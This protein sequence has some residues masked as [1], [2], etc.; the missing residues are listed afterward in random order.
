M[1]INPAI[2]RDYDVRGLYPAD[3]NAEIAR[4]IGYAFAEYLKKSCR[5]KR[6]KISIARDLRASSTALRQGLVEGIIVAGADCYDLGIAT[7]PQAIYIFGT[8]RERDGGIMITASHNP[9][10][11]NGFKLFYGRGKEIGLSSGLR[12]IRSLTRVGAKKTQNNFGRLIPTEAEGKRYVKKLHR[13]V[14]RLDSLRALI[15]AAGGAAAY[16]LPDTLA[17]YRIFYKPIFFDPDPAFHRHEPNPLAPSVT[18]L[19]RRELK[20]AKYQVG[21][22]FDGDGDRAEF[23]DEKGNPIRTDILFGLL[24]VRELEKKRGARFVFELTH[25][26]FLAP[27]IEAYGG[28]LFVTKVGGV[29]VRAEMERVGAVLGGEISGHIYHQKL[30]NIDSAIYTMLRVFSLV[31]SASR[32]VSELTRHYAS[33]YFSQSS[34]PHKAPKE[35]LAKIIAVYKPHISSRLDGVSVQNLTWWFNIRMSN[36]EPLLRLTIEAGSESEAKS[37]INEIKALLE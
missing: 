18:E 10:S 19:M 20:T 28:E 8:A 13:L 4:R 26:R 30:L 37:R 31:A 16:V 1:K 9:A 21:V 6:P 11:Y 25:S 32:P 14:P 12:T 23:F 29:H 22:A 3:I 33:G 15:D 2:F 7:T 35:A 27:L 24:A 34:I 36:T 5:T 17:P